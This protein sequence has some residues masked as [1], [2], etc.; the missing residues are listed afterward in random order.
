M[1]LKVTLYT[2][3]IDQVFA[4]RP[5][6]LLY[7]IA[8]GALSIFAISHGC[9]LPFNSDKQDLKNP[10]IISEDNFK[11]STTKQNP[12]FVSKTNKKEKPTNIVI[13]KKSTES[14]IPLNTRINTFRK[15]YTNKYQDALITIKALYPS[16]AVA[17]KDYID[18]ANNLEKYFKDNEYQGDTEKVRG[19]ELLERSIMNFIKG[20]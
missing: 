15:N 3:N 9:E 4:S 10:A 1:N 2:E 5:A 11:S 6:F 16:K 19:I 20:G 13:T 7:G 17:A 8:I 12:S 14:E 18:K